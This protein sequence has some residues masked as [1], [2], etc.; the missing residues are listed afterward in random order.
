LDRE[1]YN[2]NNPFWHCA[3][4]GVK[5]V[6]PLLIMLA[7][8]W[9][10]SS[11]KNSNDIDRD[12]TLTLAAGAIRNNPFGVA[13]PKES[14][15]VQPLLIMVG[16]TQRHFASAISNN[17]NNNNGCTYLGSLD[18]E[19][20]NW[21]NPFWCLAAKG[22]KA[23]I[24]TVENAGIFVASAIR[25][26]N[27]DCTYL[28]SLGCETYNI[29]NPFRLCAAQRFKVSK[30]IVDNTRIFAVMFTSAICKNFCDSNSGCI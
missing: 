24:V 14:R 26:N 13:L 11:T 21:N 8:L 4:Q 30:A 6:Q 2:R 27:S 19:T 10:H 28:G 15:Q 9:Q 16:F 25:K 29:N 3:A 18:S 22:V 17:D 12:C 5:Q 7:F 23:S 20:Y 1:A